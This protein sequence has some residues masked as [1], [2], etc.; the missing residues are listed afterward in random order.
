[1]AVGGIILASG[2]SSRMGKPKLL[3]KINGKPIFRWVMETAI[4]AKVNPVVVVAGELYEQYCEI[5]K[6]L[7]E[8][9]FVRN[10]EYVEGMSSSLRLGVSCLYSET[11]ALMVFLG[12]Q[13]LVPSLVVEELLSF[14]HS[15]SSLETN[16]NPLIIRPQYGNKVGHPVLFDR[17]LYDELKKVNGDKGARDLIK[18]YCHRL[19]LVSFQ[20]E[21][22]GLD[23]DTP[24]DFKNIIKAAKKGMI[25]DIYT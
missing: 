24:L 1:M 19:K 6:D 10:T 5:G 16:Q 4:N 18:K 22:W 20:N 13:P 15:N 25:D 2:F 11:E 7:S 21:I 3:L 17:S 12:D 8:I 9:R 14:Y 23:I